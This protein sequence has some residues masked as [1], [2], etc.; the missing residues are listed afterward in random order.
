M[1]KYTWSSR[2]NGSTSSNMNAIAYGIAN[3]AVATAAKSR[4][5]SVSVWMVLASLRFRFFLIATNKQVKDWM[6]DVCS[7]KDGLCCPKK[8]NYEYTLVKNGQRL[9]K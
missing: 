3:R 5:A 9:L 4:R 2:W 6:N 8:N 1:L 7:T